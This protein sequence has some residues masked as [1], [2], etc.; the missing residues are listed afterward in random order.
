MQ[1]HLYEHFYSESHNGFL[2]NVSISLIDKTDGFQPKKRE[3]YWMRTLKTVAPLGLN[4]ES[5]VWHCVFV[6]LFWTELF[7]DWELWIRLWFYIYF[8]FILHLW[9]QYW[10]HLEAIRSISNVNRLIGFYV[11]W[12]LWSR[13]IVLTLYMFSV[14]YLSIYLL[15]VIFAFVYLYY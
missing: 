15:Y 10:H 2:G 13:C 14:F 8:V 1:Q 12:T 9:S 3:S 6:Q 4:I 5:S 11:I 7:L